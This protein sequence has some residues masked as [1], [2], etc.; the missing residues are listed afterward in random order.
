[1]TLQNQE[2]KDRCE[3]R[4][5]CRMRK[6]PTMQKMLRNCGSTSEGAKGSSSLMRLQKRGFAFTC[7]RISI[8]FNF[9]IQPPRDPRISSMSARGG[10][11]APGPWSRLKPVNV[12]PLEVIGLPSKG[13][14]R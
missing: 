5:N 14:H 4:C 13:D 10:R 7:S 1:M 9:P 8:H 3:K 6:L 11:A 2:S 12:D